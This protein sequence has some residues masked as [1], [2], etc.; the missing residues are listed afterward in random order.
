MEGVIPEF[1]KIA[2]EFDMFSASMLVLDECHSV[3]A[4]PFLFGMVLR[5]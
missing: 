3:D 5:V 1:S 2:L 4:I